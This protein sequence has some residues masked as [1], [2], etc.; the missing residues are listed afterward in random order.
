MNSKLDGGWLFEY[1]YDTASEK[2]PIISRRW[3]FRSA[4]EIDAPMTAEQ[5]RQ[6]ILLM[7][8]PEDVR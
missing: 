7:L 3:R 6:R 8:K 1:E 4:H 2:D 5:K